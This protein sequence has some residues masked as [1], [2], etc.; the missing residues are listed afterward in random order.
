MTTG[1]IQEEGNKNSID[2]IACVAARL[3][4]RSSVSRAKSFINYCGND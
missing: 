1:K 4:Y 3:A 2:E